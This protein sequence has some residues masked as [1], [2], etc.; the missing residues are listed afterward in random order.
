MYQA[1]KG[2]KQKVPCTNNYGRWL[3]RWHSASC[4]TTF[5]YIFFFHPFKS[6]Y[7]CFDIRLELANK[8]SGFNRFLSTFVLISC[9]QQNQTK[10]NLIRLHLLCLWRLQRKKRKEE[11]RPRYLLNFNFI[12]GSKNYS[13]GVEILPEPKWNGHVARRKVLKYTCRSRWM[14]SHKSVFYRVGSAG[15]GLLAADIVS[16]MC[17]L[18][19]PA[20]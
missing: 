10:L 2:K 9:L 17:S 15:V 6:P 16:A 7:S 4:M 14:I 12:F 11:K 1:N 20:W 18:L 8:F 19:A 3:R 13:V 5:V